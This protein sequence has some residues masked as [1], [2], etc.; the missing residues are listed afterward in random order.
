MTIREGRFFLWNSNGAK[1][2]DP[3]IWP[4]FAHDPWNSNDVE[5]DAQRPRVITDLRA[6]PTS[7]GRQMTLEWTAPGDDGRC[8][9]AHSYEARRAGT[10]LETDTFI[11]GTPIEG[12]PTVGSGGALQQMTV[13]RQCSGDTYVAIRT[14]DANPERNDTGSANYNAAHPANPSAVNPLG[15]NVLIPQR[16]ASLCGA[17]STTA[18]PS[19]P[20]PT[21]PGGTPISASPR[22]G[23]PTPSKSTAPSQSGT[24]SGSPTEP[25]RA[26]TSLETSRSK[27]RLRAA[28]NLSGRVTGSP[29]CAAPYDITI[30]R[31]L[32]GTD[33]FRTLKATQTDAQ[34]IW[35]TTIHPT[36]NATYRAG[37]ESRS[38][39][40]GELSSPADVLVRVKVAARTGRTCRAG[41]S[42]RVRP[43]YPGRF[44]E[45][46]WRKDHRWHDVERDKLS[47]RSRFKLHPERCNGPVYR[48][49]WRKQSERNIW[50]KSRPLHP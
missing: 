19:S 12:E 33:Q 24:P 8:G 48:V 17:A 28:V 13:T 6:T 2:C 50:G 11:S 31:R 16:P 22:T 35:Q 45:L 43:P 34:G 14:W 30:E 26:T 41:I 20:P 3:A 47:R 46:Q 15:S 4:D 21:S 37:V 38:D 9:K 1:V 23:S 39:C 18:P 5:T 49:V 27:T 7:D 40:A 42:G 10:P 32:H 25:G 44:V 29:P 36:R